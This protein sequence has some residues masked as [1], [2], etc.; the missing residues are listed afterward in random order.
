MASLDF[1]L[2]KIGI[3]NRKR[4]PKLRKPT[5]RSGIKKKHKH[6][7]RQGGNLGFGTCR[8]NVFGELASRRS[9][10]NGNVLSSSAI[11][12]NTRRLEGGGNSPHFVFGRAL[13][14]SVQ[15]RSVRRPA[16]RRPPSYPVPLPA[17]VPARFRYEQAARASGSGACPS[18][19][20]SPRHGSPQRAGQRKARLACPARCGP[21]DH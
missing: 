18:P 17:T 4:F 6:L 8:A 21:E 10:R 20:P 15:P 9:V 5:N 7:A 14:S 11:R 3:W 12:P 1:H 16:R 19:R 2:P 13:P